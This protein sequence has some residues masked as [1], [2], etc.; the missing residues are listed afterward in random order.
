V[1]LI[2]RVCDYYEAYIDEPVFYLMRALHSNNLLHIKITRLNKFMIIVKWWIPESILVGEFVLKDLNWEVIDDNLYYRI[3]GSCILALARANE[4]FRNSRIVPQIQE[5]CVSLS[6]ISTISEKEQEKVKFALGQEDEY[7][8]LIYPARAQ[9]DVVL[10]TGASFKSPTTANIAL[11]VLSVFHRLKT[12]ERYNARMAINEIIQHF[13]S[14][15]YS[16]WEEK[17]KIGFATRGKFVIDNPLFSGITALGLGSRK[18]IAEEKA[19]YLV[20]SQLVETIPACNGAN[21]IISD[22]E[23]DDMDEVPVLKKITILMENETC[24]TQTEK[25]NIQKCL[26]CLGFYASYAVERIETHEFKYSVR[27]ELN[28]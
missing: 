12:E 22:S 14:S 24:F 25:E 21:T 16:F 8:G 7:I 5:R 2:N 15:A 6:N 1:E 27:E 26:R 4:K 13:D 11:I 17:T 28:E 23:D 10:S 18:K 20:L 3:H 9:G 19:A